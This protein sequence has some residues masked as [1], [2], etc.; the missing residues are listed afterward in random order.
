MAVACG[1]AVAVDVVVA[2]A[3]G[4]AVGR[5][6]AIIG[7]AVGAVGGV[8]TAF[9]ADELGAGAAQPASKATSAMLGATTR[10][11][12]KTRDYIHVVLDLKKRTLRS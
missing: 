12:T 4:D 10:K 7:V 2:V 5:A 1:V 9:A 8:G 3:T 6:G 11:R